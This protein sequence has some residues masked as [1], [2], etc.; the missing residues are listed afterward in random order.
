MRHTVLFL[1][2]VFTQTRNVEIIIIIII[3]VLIYK[4]K[5]HL[6][7][8]DELCHSASSVTTGISTA[9]FPLEACQRRLCKSGFSRDLLTKIAESEIS[10]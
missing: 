6:A 9:N 10:V 3:I 7:T 2:V 8:V 4:S 5:T 1:V